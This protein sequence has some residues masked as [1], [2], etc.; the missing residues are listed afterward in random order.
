[1][2]RAAATA[3]APDGAFNVDRMLES[4]LEDYDGSP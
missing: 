2:I 3:Y 4:L 1:V